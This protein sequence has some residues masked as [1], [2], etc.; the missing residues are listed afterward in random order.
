MLA[1]AAL[2]A[3]LSRRPGA[4]FAL[5]AWN[6]VLALHFAG[7][8]HNDAWLAAL[9]V[10]ALA[11]GA[12]G[13]PSGEGA[14]WALG[15]LVKWVPLA[16]LP[17]RLL[18]LRGRRGLL[19]RLVAGAALAAALV[20]VLAT[21]RYGSGWIEAVTPLV[22]NARAETEYAFP[23][24]VTQLGAPRWLALGLALAG[25]AVAYALLARRAARG[26]ARLGLAAG[27]LLLATPY[28]APWYLAWLVPLA[29]AE[30]DAAARRLSL[31]LSAYLLPQTIPL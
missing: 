5:V 4:A 30:D 18:E 8:G 24:R 19:A 3:R 2:A 31:A 13:R 27:L 1:A 22:R 21:W 7:G 10:G 17:L 16:L 25:F 23:H 15:A 12:S 28:L 26:R 6:P 29:A 14:A 9:M 11:L 20:A